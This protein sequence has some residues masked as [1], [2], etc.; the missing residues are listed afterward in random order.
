MAIRHMI[1]DYNGIERTAKKNLEGFYKKLLHSLAGYTN[2]GIKPGRK[3]PP[4][5]D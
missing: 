2:I 5:R 3:L 1:I 4:K